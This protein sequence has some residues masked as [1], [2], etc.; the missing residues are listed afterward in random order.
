MFSEVFYKT[1]KAYI[2]GV[3]VPI[4]RVDYILR[5]LEIP[6]GDHII[7]F[8]NVDEVYVRASLY[9]KIASVIVGLVFMLLAV[10]AVWKHQ[11]KMK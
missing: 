9:S 4:V 1:W 3:E 7:E 2:D 5:G 6:A 11:K 10:F 8:K